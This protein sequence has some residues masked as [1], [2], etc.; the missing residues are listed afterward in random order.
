MYAV[1]KIGESNI[2]IQRSKFI[3]YC[4]PIANIEQAE[5]C[6]KD[7]RRKHAQA[8]HIVYVYKLL[9]DIL[10]K[11][12]S[13]EPSGTGAPPIQTIL[14]N[15]NMTNVLVAVVRYFGGVLLGTG[16]LVRAYSECA[17]EAINDAIPKE[18]TKYYKYKVT[19][20]YSNISEVEKMDVII[21]DREYGDKVIYNIASKT[22]NF[23]FDNIEY[24]GEIWL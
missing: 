15:M 7:I 12:N 22:Q 17:M 11:Y 8:K 6:L 13:S 16:G 18:L 5:E 14:D 1:T 21:L 3:G 4:I 19:I 10:R 23:Q 2:N 24:L 9:P 20:D